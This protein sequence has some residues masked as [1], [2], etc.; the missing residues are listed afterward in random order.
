[1]RK[2][3]LTVLVGITLLTAQEDLENPFLGDDNF[4]MGYSLMADSMPNFMHIY[5]KGGG[6]HKLNLSDKQEEAIEKVFATRP[7]QMMKAASEIEKLE[8]KLVLKVV[9]EGKNAKEVKALLDEIAL[10]R[11]EMTILK[12]SCVN[13]FKETLTEKQYKSLRDM[14]I[15][16]ADSL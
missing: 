10:K 1:L 16:V 9:D 5:M 14:A 6:M 2:I 15:K 12:I 7:S 3:I 11:K 4:P 13:I 8:T